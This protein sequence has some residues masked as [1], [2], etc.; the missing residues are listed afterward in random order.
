MNYTKYI[1]FIT[2]LGIALFTAPLFEIMRNTVPLWAFIAITILAIIGPASP[3][4][5]QGK[6][7]FSDN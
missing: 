6:N 4:L 5:L 7:P 2:L 1:V 3:A